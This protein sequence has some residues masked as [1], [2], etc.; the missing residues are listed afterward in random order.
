MKTIY[1]GKC[2]CGQEYHIIENVNYEMEYDNNLIK[3]VGK[4]AVCVQCGEELFVEEIEEY[5]QN[6]F[7]EAYK[8]QLEIISTDQIDEILK[9]YNIP[10]TI[11]IVNDLL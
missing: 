1:C 6:A 9:K 3:Y 4:K 10:A 7:E 11:F 5:N 2:Q 8:Q